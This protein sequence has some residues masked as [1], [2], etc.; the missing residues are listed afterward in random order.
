MFERIGPNELP[1][2]LRRYRLAG[3][4]IRRMRVVY[5]RPREAAVE[6][7]LTV[8]ETLKDLG[9]S[10]RTARLV[11]RLEGVEEFRIQMRPN[12]P[13]SKIVEARVGYLNGLFFVN[14]DAWGL[15]PGELAKLHDYRA[16]ETYAGGRELLWREIRRE[17]PASSPDAPDA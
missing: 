11:L 1:A 13:K 10:P 7:H 2:F 12:Q 6:F 4:R 14:F 16:S 9:E 8:R 17:D 5:P 3:G 15:G